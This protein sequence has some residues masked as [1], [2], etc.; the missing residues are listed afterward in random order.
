M[1][2][3][4]GIR[5]TES[6]RPSLWPLRRERQAIAAAKF[7]KQVLDALSNL[8]ARL[9]LLE[10]C[11]PCYTQQSI[12][13]LEELLSKINAIHNML[14]KNCSE[15]PALLKACSAVAVQT[16]PTVNANILEEQLSV[17]SE[18]CTPK[19]TIG[20]QPEMEV[21]PPK[22]M[23]KT[24][25]ANIDLDGQKR[26]V[27]LEALNS[28]TGTSNEESGAAEQEL[29]DKNG[30]E[31]AELNSE[32][33]EVEVELHSMAGTG[34]ESLGQ[35][36]PEM[37]AEMR[38]QRLLRTHAIEDSEDERVLEMYFPSRDSGEE[39]NEDSEAA[40]TSEESCS[41]EGG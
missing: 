27:E 10:G 26:E 40:E 1:A 36:I 22:C 8:D 16:S 35:T 38:L 39:S 13:Q 2:G 19:Q 25:D 12:P 21:S 5:D 9:T 33:A 34:V 31:D 41:T 11:R 15:T 4:N 17:N 37:D 23:Q 24:G 3:L 30:A 28:K 6:A 18:P 14:E 20:W 29:E 32:T 7:Q